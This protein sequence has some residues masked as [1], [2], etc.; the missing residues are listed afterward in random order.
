MPTPCSATR[1]TSP[2][3]A[4]AAPREQSGWPRRCALRAGSQPRDAVGPRLDGAVAEAHLGAFQPDV[5]VLGEA[6][7]QVAGVEQ[8]EADAGLGRRLDESLAHRIVGVRNAPRVVVQIVEL[9]D[10]V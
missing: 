1:A 7:A 8:R 4:C 5:A 9:A 10:E 6:A 3:R 2:A